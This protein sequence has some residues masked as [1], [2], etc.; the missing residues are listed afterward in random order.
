MMSLLEI[1]HLNIGIKYKF[2]FLSAYSQVMNYLLK[3]VYCSH[4][5]EGIL[6]VLSNIYKEMFNKL[7]KQ[8]NY[9]RIITGAP[10]SFI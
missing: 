2:S 4:C 6:R 10:H 8:K 1:L 7:K 5:V 9:I 3:I